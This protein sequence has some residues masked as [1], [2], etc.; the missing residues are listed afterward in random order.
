MRVRV[1]VQLLPPCCG[2]LDLRDAHP[3]ECYMKTRHMNNLGLYV[4]AREIALLFCPAL[5][6]VNRKSSTGVMK[7]M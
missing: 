4:P 6:G 7:S 1:L 2:L 3:F 5:Q